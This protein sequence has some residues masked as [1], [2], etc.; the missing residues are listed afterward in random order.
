MFEGIGVSP[1]IVVGK[2]Y[3]VDQWKSKT[4][5]FELSPSEVEAE[6]KRFRK[7]IAVSKDQLKLIKQKVASEV[8]DQT[9]AYIIDVHLIIM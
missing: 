5:Q 4:E 8:E 9:Y 1:G 7:A 2:A 3:V 6:I